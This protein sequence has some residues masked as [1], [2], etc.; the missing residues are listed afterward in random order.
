MN[1][2]EFDSKA[3]ERYRR[4]GVFGNPDTPRKV[5]LN[6]LSH[7]L[8]PS[9][10]DFALILVSGIATGLAVWFDLPALLVPVF[11]VFPFLGTFF[12]SLLGLTTGSFRFAGRSFANFLVLMA[13]FFF[14]AFAVGFVSRGIAPTIQLTFYHADTPSAVL[15]LACG[16]CVFFA[17]TR[18]VV[19]VDRVPEALTTAG[20]ASVWLPLGISG[21]LIGA[22]ISGGS[23]ALRTALLGLAVNLFVSLIALYVLRLFTAKAAALAVSAALFILTLAWTFS[24]RFVIIADARETVARIRSRFGTPV[25]VATLASEEPESEPPQSAPNPPAASINPASLSTGNSAN[26]FSVQATETEVRPTL[27]P[28]EATV[29]DAVAVLTVA[30]VKEKFGINM[31][32]GATPEVPAAGAEVVPSEVPPTLT[33]TVHPSD[34][35][36]PVPTAT[37]TLVPTATVTATRTPVP[38]KA[39]VPTITV[40]L[41]RTLRPTSTATVTFTAAPPVNYALVNVENDVGVLVRLSPEFNAVVMK[42]VMNGSLLEIMGEERTLPYQNYTWIKVRT[43]DGYVGWVGKDGLVFDDDALP[44]NAPSETPTSLPT[45]VSMIVPTAIPTVQIMTLTPGGPEPPNEDAVAIVHAE[46]DV[47]LLVHVSPASS[48]QVM[49][50]VWNGSRMTLVGEESQA[51]P[52]ET[53]W[54]RVRTEDGYV[55]WA[56]R[57]F[58]LLPGETPPA[59]SS[60]AP[61]EANVASLIPTQPA[62]ENYAVV[63]AENG[64]GEVLRLKPDWNSVVMKAIFNGAQLVLTG[65]ERTTSDKTNWVEVRTESGHVGW[66]NKKSLFLSD[67]RDAIIP[68]PTTVP[69]EKFA[70]VDANDAF[71][72]AVFESPSWNATIMVSVRNG[73]PIELTGE[74]RISTFDRSAWVQVRLDSGHIGWVNKATLR[75]TSSPIAAAPTATFEPSD[76]YAVVR[77]NDDYGVAVLDS[78]NWN[79]TIMRSIRNGERLEL[80]GTERISGSDRSIW[81]QVRLD[82]GHIGWVRKA[83]LLMPSVSEEEILAMTRTVE[84]ELASRTDYYAVVR[85]EDDIGTVIRQ[86]PEWNSSIMMSVLNGSKLDLTG[87]EQNAGPGKTSWIQVRTDDGY[88]GWVDRSRLFFPNEPTPTPVPTYHPVVKVTTGPMVHYAVVFVPNEAGVAVHLN[89]EL[90]SEVHRAVLNGSLIELIDDDDADSQPELKAWVKVRTNDGYVGWVGR[91]SLIYPEK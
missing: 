17:I 76:D 28:P 8:T 84:R 31:M 20:M 65:E 79:A 73:L 47:G 35:P 10:G 81:V 18:F 54:V 62:P 50:A 2:T 51:G 14:G 12:G 3:R 43:S 85:A 58:L 71:G 67:S 86:S 60:G 49:K 78:P 22:G 68:T 23:E 37:D 44:I 39:V 1:E 13:L 5:Y 56:R 91:D 11:A 69:S 26:D 53:L 66:V 24:W 48:A 38:T 4:R 27:A 80:T 64:V 25:S 77:G 33:A 83:L 9:V 16:F 59:D 36:V 21:F 82:S 46:N 19:R 40:T 32:S 7:R 52:D 30:S 88:V 45:V 70:V 42:S 72:T 90:D 6:E 15:M 75:I 61:A 55:G 74:E 41:T 87:K 89:P 63:Q 34:T 57:S 29:D